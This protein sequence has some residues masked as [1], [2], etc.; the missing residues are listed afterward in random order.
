M[1]NALVTQVEEQEVPSWSLVGGRGMPVAAAWQE[2][3]KGQ[4]QHLLE[5]CALHSLNE[6]MF[7]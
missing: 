5:C 3:A 2:V 1:V 7:S 4:K 6:F